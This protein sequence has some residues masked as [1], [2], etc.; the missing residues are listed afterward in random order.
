MAYSDFSFERAIADFQLQKEYSVIFTSPD[1]IPPSDWLL[2]TLKRGRSFA[3]PGGSEKARS[4]F[5]V[6]PILTE[7]QHHCG[8]TITIYSG[9]NLDVEK[10]KGLAGECDFLLGRGMGS[11]TLQAPLLTVVEAKRNDIDIGLGQCVAQM[12]G[13]QRFNQ[14]HSVSID[15]VF[16][17]VTTGEIWQFLRLSGSILTIDSDRFYIKSVD[18][19][20]GCLAQ[21]IKDHSSG[22]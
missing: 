11:L 3:I 5:I 4:E 19:I 12:V 9:R 10:E 13:V 8:E 14:N 15:S 1:P 6:A 18:E 7:A 17:C 21:C 2:E 20:L 22:A 16:G